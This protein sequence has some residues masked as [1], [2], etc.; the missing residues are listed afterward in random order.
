M[1]WKEISPVEQRIKFIA[2]LHRGLYSMTDLCDR[3]GV[4]RKTG[5]KWRQRHLE[6]GQT[7]LLDRSHATHCC[8]HRMPDEVADLILWARLEHPDWGARKLIKWLRPRCPEVQR[9]PARSSASN[10]LARLGLI[11]PTR[12]RHKP[13]HPGAVAPTTHEPND[14]WTA[15]FKGQFRT[16][17]RIECFPLTIADQHT[18]FLLTC[19]GLPSVATLGAWPV[20]EKAFR[21]FGLPKAIR[22][23]NGAPFCSKAIHGL[24]HLNVWWLRLGIQH[25]RIR[26]VSPQEN[27][28]HERMHR[29][30]KRTACRPVRANRT[31]QQRAFAHFREE[32]NDERPHEAIDDEPPGSRYQT[33]SRPY[34]AKLPTIEYPG[35]FTVK[36]VTH[37]GTI[38]FRHKLFF[39]SRTL[40]TL[41][42]GLEE[43]DDGIWALYFQELLLA[44]IDERTMNLSF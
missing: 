8:P 17:D 19:H 43:T 20:F 33:S 26:P 6:E 3:Y 2:D 31:A 40:D 1:P 7:G 5:Y 27:G 24:S 16:R 11:P 9:W 23:D 29:T 13:K 25:Q 44:K 32:F 34:T 4:S 14:L 39:L 15:D 22:T 10:L 12:R 28:A 21:E 37:Q 30:L 41:P 36:R 42:I 35:H 18:R 38:R